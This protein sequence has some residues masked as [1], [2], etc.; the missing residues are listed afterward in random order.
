[1]MAEEP[2]EINLES[3]YLKLLKEMTAEDWEKEYQFEW[4][5][6]PD[7]KIQYKETELGTVVLDVERIKNADFG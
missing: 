7:N 3:R 5:T 4:K 1:M 2:I 6:T